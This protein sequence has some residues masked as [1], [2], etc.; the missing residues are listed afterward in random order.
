M[1]KMSGGVLSCGVALLLSLTSMSA[2]QMLYSIDGFKD[3]D[4]GSSVPEHSLMLLHWFANTVQ[5][6]ANGVISLNFDLIR[7]DY[8][9]HHYGNYERVLNSRP[10]GYQYY[11]I[12]NVHRDTSRQLP[13]YVRNNQ[14]EFVA[15]N[16]DRIIIRVQEQ[17]TGQ[18]LCGE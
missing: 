12:G 3:I 11:T 6:N 8:G 7:G 1:M 17:N 2:V 5:I 15:G 16:R 4:F 9:A 14:G 13:S 10:W 18:E